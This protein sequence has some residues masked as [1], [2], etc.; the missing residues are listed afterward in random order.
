M[1]KSLLVAMD[2]TPGSEAARR[3]ACAL[4]SASGASLTG[5]GNLDIAALTAPVAVPL[6]GAHYKAHAD[7]QRVRDVDAH[8]ERARA[9]F[10]SEA[11]AAGVRASAILTSGDTVRDL[12]DAAASHDAVVLGLDT[13]FSGAASEGLARTVE[14]VLKNN[15]RPLILT[16]R[17]AATVSRVL[18]AFDGSVPSARAL[19]LFVLLG[20]PAIAPVHVTTIARDVGSARI[21]ANSAENYLALYGHE[22]HLRPVASSEDPAE[23]LLGEMRAIGADL[24]V[25]GAYGHR[26]WRE[27]LLG[28]CTTRLLSKSPASLFI[29]H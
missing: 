25:M 5:F 2:E 7:I 26:G 17:G 22:V 8:R 24:L 12:L 21:L 10:L 11:A 16:P 6:G 29:H 15:P 14:R 27:A 3:V 9:K 23:V 20:L 19:Q 4:A 1:V 13:D 28:S 18:V